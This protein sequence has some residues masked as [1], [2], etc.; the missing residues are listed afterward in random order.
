MK[1]RFV[2]E[3]AIGLLKGSWKILQDLNVGLHHTP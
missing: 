1:G 2:V 3:Q